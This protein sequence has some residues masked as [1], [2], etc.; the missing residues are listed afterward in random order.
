MREDTVETVQD[1]NRGSSRVDEVEVFEFDSSLN[2]VQLDSFV[3]SGIDDGNSVDRGEDLGSGSCS[4][5]EGLQVGGEHG[6]GERS[7]QD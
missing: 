1:L 2:L 7:D 6:E 3:R 5:R 4:T